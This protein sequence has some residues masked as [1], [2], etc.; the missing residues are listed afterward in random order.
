MPAEM[1]FEG[2]DEISEMLTELAEKA[3]GVA[4]RGLYEGAGIMRD[5][6]AAEVKT[7]QTAPFRRAVGYQRLPSP[8]EKAIV[9]AGTVGIAKFDK[10]G[11]E[12]GTSVGFSDAGYARAGWKN[13]AM[14]PI[15]QVA[16]AINSGT[17]FMKKQ[18]FVRRAANSAKARAESA[19]RQRIESDLEELIKD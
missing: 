14:K 9:E 15:A 13:G 17:S 8:E 2:M 3:Q 18:P 1:S 12:V 5:S 10:N 4:A 7:I 6:L 19:I 11:S 16:N